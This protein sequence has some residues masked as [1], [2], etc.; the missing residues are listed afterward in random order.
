MEKGEHMEKRYNQDLTE[1]SVFSQLLKFS[2]P[3]LLSMVV[4]QL[5]NMADI[6]FVSYF[7]GPDAVSG[8]NIGGQITFLA[9]SLAIGLSVGGTVLVGQYF[10]ARR[11]KDL[12]GTIATMLTSL[13]ILAAAFTTLFL[14]L[15]EP[16]LRLIQCPDESFE[17][18]KGYLDICTI[19]LVFIFLYNAV[20]GIMRGMGDSR[21]PLIIVTI[22]CILNVLLDFILVGVFGLSA[23]GAAIATVISQALSV[24]IS[25]IYLQRSSFLF[26]F[27]I[28]SFRIHVDKLKLIMKYG[29]PTGFQQIVTN[30]SFLLMT[31]LINQYGFEASAAVGLAGR[32]NGFAFMPMLAL[33]NSISMMVAQN[34]G[35]KRMDRA[36]KTLSSG[37]LLSVVVGALAFALSFFKPEWIMSI[38]TQ[39]TVVREWGSQ[40]IHAISADML[41]IAFVFSIT[42]LMNGCGHTTITFIGSLISAVGAR[43]PLAI[44]LSRY[45]GFQGIG[46]AAPLASVVACI[47]LVIYFLTGKWKVVAIHKGTADELPDPPL[48][49]Q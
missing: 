34:M 46:Y 3:F 48:E 15:D 10:G 14:I 6:L 1:G 28:K 8:V 24:V 26:D 30:F 37:M 13:L 19:G 49:L 41:M 23:K 43:I 11:T 45:F 17:S 36:Q 5:Y 29:I 4:Q 22:T 31:T 18:A 2:I 35:A 12:L 16:I 38:M 7:A 39:D 44:L 20:S 33:S 25:I 9:N 47:V 27:K 32:F 40:Y 21:R 42:G